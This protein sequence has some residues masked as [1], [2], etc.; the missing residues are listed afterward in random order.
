M[1][2]PLVAFSIKFTIESLSHMLNDIVNNFLNNVLNSVFNSVLN[3]VFNS[4]FNKKCDIAKCIFL[5][6]IYIKS[7]SINVLKIFSR[8]FSSDYDYEFKPVSMICCM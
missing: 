3:G 8:F 7:T 4:V 6:Q 1:K 5:N 2:A